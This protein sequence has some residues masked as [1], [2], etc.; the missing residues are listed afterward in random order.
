[1]KPKLIKSADRFFTL[2]AYW[3]PVVQLHLYILATQIRCHVVQIVLTSR[4][5]K[6][7]ADLILDM[8]QMKLPMEDDTTGGAAGGTAPVCIRDYARDENLITRVNPALTEH[9][10]NP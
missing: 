4:D 3:S 9:R 2:F 10:F 7:L 6:L 8:N 1:M 5:T